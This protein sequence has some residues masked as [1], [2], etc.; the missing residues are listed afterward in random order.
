MDSEFRLAHATTN[1]VVRGDKAF[2][3]SDNRLFALP[4]ATGEEQVLAKLPDFKEDD[5]PHELVATDAGLL[6]RGEM[7]VMFV[8]YS[9]KLVHHTSFKRPGHSIF[10]RAAAAGL[11][12]AASRAADNEN[13]LLGAAIRSG[14]VG[15]GDPDDLRK[16]TTQTVHTGMRSVM[17]GTVKRPTREDNGFIMFDATTGQPLG[18]IITA[19]LLNSAA[20]SDKHVD[21][22]FNLETGWVNY[23]EITNGNGV[24]GGWKIGA[25]K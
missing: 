11:N 16:R 15:I 22:A 17:Y 13:D 14:S 18:D 8:D 7:N 19:G 25:K 12:V 9:G 6:L 20:F 10:V 23:L 3:W 4:L 2:I 21:L 5:V 1:F 24:L